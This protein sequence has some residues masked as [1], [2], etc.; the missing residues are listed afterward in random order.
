MATTPRKEEGK[1]NCLFV[2]NYAR[3]LFSFVCLFVCLFVVVCLFVC[4]VCLFFV[5]FVPP[6]WP[7]DDIK[8]FF[9]YRMSANES[10]CLLFCLKVR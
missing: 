9:Q 1:C 7:E 2:D 6:V 3:F 8:G 10:V 4:F 5:C